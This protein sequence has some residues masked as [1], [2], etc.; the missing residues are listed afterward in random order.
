MGRQPAGSQA[1]GQD[2]ALTPAGP[3]SNGA[4]TDT[5]EG[6]SIYLPFSALK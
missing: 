6:K 1:A 2:R 4:A 5:M 3:R